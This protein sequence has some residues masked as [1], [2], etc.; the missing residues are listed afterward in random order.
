MEECH[1]SMP[2]DNMYL[3]HLMMHAQ[4]LEE[5]R[6]KRKIKDA[7]RVKFYEVKLLWEGCKFK[8]SLHSIRGSL[9]KFLLS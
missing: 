5:S 9:I 2:Y 8:A 3:S 1:A 7:K 4:Q 6:L